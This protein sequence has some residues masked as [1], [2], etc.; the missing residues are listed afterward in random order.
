VFLVNVPIMAL[1]LIIGLPTLRESRD[2]EPQG[3]STC[4]RWP[5]RWW[6]I[7]GVVYAIKELAIRGFEVQYLVD[8]GHR[9][10][11]R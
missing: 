6:G 3:R 8:R 9:C 4:C 5:C 11:P 1:V 7:L 10:G 2:P